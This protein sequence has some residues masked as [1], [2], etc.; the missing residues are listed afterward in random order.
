MVTCVR[1]EA[2]RRTATD[3][4]GNHTL[5]LRHQAVYSLSDCVSE[6][7]CMVIDDERWKTLKLNQLKQLQLRARRHCSQLR[8]W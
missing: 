2:G 6:M 3:N 1:N 7:C 5:D 4:T 8:R